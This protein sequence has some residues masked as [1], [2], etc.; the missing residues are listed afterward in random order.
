MALDLQSRKQRLDEMLSNTIDSAKRRRIM[1]LVEAHNK[2][3]ERE[4][5]RRQ[6]DLD[7]SVEEI[8]EMA[9]ELFEGEWSEENLLRQQFPPRLTSPEGTY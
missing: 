9:K 8:L 3:V 5:A 1:K 2:E 7:E 4:V 6:R